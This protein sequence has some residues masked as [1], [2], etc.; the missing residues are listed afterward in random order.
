MRRVL[1][2]AFGLAVFSAPL[3]AQQRPRSDSLPREL[4]IALLGGSLGGRSVEVHAG[5]ADDSLPTDLFR[6]ALLLG[7][8]DYRASRTTV[9]YFPYAPQATIDTIK[10]RLVAAGWTAPPVD[11]DTVRGFVT[12]YGGPRPQVICRGRSVIVPTVM[13]RTINRTL[14]VISRQG[15]QGADFYC[16]ANP[17]SRM[18]RMSPAADTPLPAL[19]PPAGMQS[20][21]AGTSGSLSRERGMSMSTSLV[22]SVPLRDIMSHYAELFTRAGWRKVEEQLASSIGVVTFEIT[23]KGE[24]WHCAFVVS[25]PADDAT[26]VHL[27]LRIR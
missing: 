19:T 16:G 6:D 26:D 20:R 14:A 7:F 23:V 2:A 22:G 15:S 8:A 17:R 24:S 1:V 11:P 9:A 25:I 5:L 13:V 12:A 4:V 18:E 21:S 3:L 27:M 10:A